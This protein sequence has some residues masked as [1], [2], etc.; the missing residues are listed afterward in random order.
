LKVD[1]NDKEALEQQTLHDVEKHFLSSCKKRIESKLS[2]SLSYNPLS[3][4]MVIKFIIASFFRTGHALVLKTA[5]PDNKERQAL[6]QRYVQTI[7]KN[8]LSDTETRLA[9]L[10]T[11]SPTEHYMRE[12]LYYLYKKY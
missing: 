8:I 6:R 3:N 9:D 12:P 7:T 2:D 10:S 5:Y 1:I 11:F 4:R